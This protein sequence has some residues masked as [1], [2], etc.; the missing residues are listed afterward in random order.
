MALD[1]AIQG[2]RHTGQKITWHNGD[3]G[4]QNLTGATLTGVIR[5]EITGQIRDIDGVLAPDATDGAN[6][7]FLW[8]Y[9]VGDV[10]VSGTFSVQFVATYPDGKD[11][12]TFVETWIV[13]PSLGDV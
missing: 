8:S 5:D 11:D 12:R 2:A 1:I 13:A 3:G 10:G 4:F 6:G 9:G 7:V